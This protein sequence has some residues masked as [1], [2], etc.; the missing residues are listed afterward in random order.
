MNWKSKN[1]K[2]LNVCCVL[3]DWKFPVLESDDLKMIN[4]YYKAH[5]CI[6]VAPVVPVVAEVKQEERIVVQDNNLILLE[7]ILEELKKLNKSLKK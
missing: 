3:C 4:N 2:G 6:D 7:N 5:K 1:E